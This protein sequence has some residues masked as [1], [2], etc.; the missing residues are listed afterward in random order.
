MIEINYRIVA[1]NN[2]II[3]TQCFFQLNYKC[4]YFLHD[5]ESGAL[6]F[7][8]DICISLSNMRIFWFLKDNPSSGARRY[9]IF[10]ILF[11]IWINT[12]CNLSKINGDVI[13]KVA[14]NAISYWFWHFL[15]QW[16]FSLEKKRYRFFVPYSYVI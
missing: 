12:W 8:F 4:I 14:P 7:F 3:L 10:F 16:K 15:N 1:P 9:I 13:F 6:H 2:S 11:F 5:C